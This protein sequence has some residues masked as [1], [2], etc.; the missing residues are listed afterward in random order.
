M[1]SDQKR[2]LTP[3]EFYRKI[4]AENFSDSHVIY[5]IELPRETLA[6]ELSEIS[7]NQKQDQEV[8]ET[9]PGNRHAWIPA[10]VQKIPDKETQNHQLDI[11]DGHGFNQ[12]IPHILTPLR[13]QRFP[14]CG[15]LMPSHAS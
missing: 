9:D 14:G 7:K 13:V 12:E 11:G 2:I 10:V 1:K 4:R 3:S 8:D 6:F 15:C 5:D